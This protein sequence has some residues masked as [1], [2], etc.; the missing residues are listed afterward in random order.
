MFIRLHIILYQCL[1]EDGRCTLVKLLQ[2]LIDWATGTLHP[3]CSG[4]RRRFNNTGCV[5]NQQCCDA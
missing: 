5:V 4:I 3:V 1:I 2:D